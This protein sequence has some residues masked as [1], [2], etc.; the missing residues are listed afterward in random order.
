MGECLGGYGV[1][2]VYGGPKVAAPTGLVLA[3]DPANKKS[4]SQNEFQY[5]T[6]IVTF[7]GTGSN[8]ATITRD[9]INSPVG[10]TPLKMAVTGND[11]YVN[12]YNT[13]SRNIAP[14]ANGQTW[15][16]SVYVKA[17]VATTGQIFIFG[18]AA[19]G[20]VFDAVT[21]QI[22]AGG[23]SI[24]T[25][26]TR[27]WYTFTFTKGISF[28]QVRL[29]GPDS[30]G[31]GQT[32]WWDGLQVERVPSGTTTPTPYTSSYY[33]GSVFRDLVGSNN[34]TLVNYPT[35]SGSNSGSL[36]FDGT[37]DSVSIPF[38]AST[39]D[40]SLAQ[41][42][43]MWMRPTTGS[44]TARRNPY[45]QAFGGPGTLTYETN[46]TITYYFGT[47]GGN[48]LPYVGR[49]SGFT[50]AANETAFISVTRNQSTNVC[51][52]YKNGVLIT[53]ADAGG[54]ATTANGS[55]PILIGSGYVS[56][57]LGNIYYCKVYNRALTASEIQQNFIAT[58]S[59]F[60]I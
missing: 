24:G 33:G 39:M 31:T 38:N 40:F 49:G 1:M 47:N 21:G 44:N 37:D 10:S 46:G 6:D 11:P 18:A 55:S 58:R 50:I 45:N 19:N 54:Y 36:V 7:S 34:G 15:I 52:W 16:V 22:S 25:D 56:P 13:S 12:M 2:G 27:V 4:Y 20:N 60:G 43:C 5:S 29:D 53:T 42:I 35:Y 17:S 57:F 9:T 59:R 23:V 32:I 41:T 51:N 30:G 28:I 26:W 48:N 3:L 14:A 8:A